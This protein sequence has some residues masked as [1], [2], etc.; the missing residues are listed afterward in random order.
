MFPFDNPIFCRLPDW[1]AI[2]VTGAD[3]TSFLH[4]QFTN[5]VAGLGLDAT[6]YNGYCSPKGRIL[7]SFP[8]TRTGLSDYLLVVPVDVAPALIKR[9]RMFVLRAKVTVESLAESHRCFGIAGAAAAFSA[10]GS[11]VRSPTG[12]VT[13][14]LADGRRLAVCAAGDAESAEETMQRDAK[15]ADPSVWDW[16]SIIAGVPVITALTQDMFVPQMLNWELLGGVSFQKG[17]YPGQEIVARMQYLGK[18]KARMYRAHVALAGGSAAATSPV[19]ALA[20]GQP[21]YGTL[22]GDQAC[23]T[24]VNSAAAPAGGIDLLA[25]LQIASAEADT[26]RIGRD[27]DAPAIELRSLPYAIPAPKAA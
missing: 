7:A 2:A 23:G 17:C 9:L 26:I 1:T 12:A 8:L 3:A 6:Q 11:D 15:S 14:A 5:D 19:N 24:I 22:F 16:L 27:P 4:A 21:L 25:V 18:L 13:L 10:T 20:A